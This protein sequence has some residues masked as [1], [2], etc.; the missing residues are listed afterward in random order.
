MS[1][2]MNRRDSAVPDRPLSADV[3]FE[4]P[5]ARRMLPLVSRIGLDLLELRR[6]L[7]PL[8][9]ECQRLERVRRTLDWPS[10]QRRYRLQDDLVQLSSRVQDALAELAELGLVDLGVS[11][12]RLG[13]PT[14]V[15]Q[16]KAYFVWVPASPQLEFWQF[17]DER[18]LRPIP[19]EWLETV[20]AAV[21]AP[22]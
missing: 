5:T 3:L 10:R 22:S 12:I 19:R 8:E 16:R 9:A 21:S 18:Q 1:G 13:F 15:N 7:L 17:E 6:Q 14:I 4:L 11:E 2:A 20:E